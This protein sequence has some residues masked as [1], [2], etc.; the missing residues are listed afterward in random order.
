[1][2]TPEDVAFVLIAVVARPS[3]VCK[4][5][6]NEGSRNRHGDRVGNAAA[7]SR[8]SIYARLRAIMF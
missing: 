8:D 7:D 2:S 3:A 1:M 6:P 5:T 4:V